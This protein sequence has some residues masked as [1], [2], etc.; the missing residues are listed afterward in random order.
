MGTTMKTTIRARYDGKVLHPIEPLDLPADSE[1]VITVEE[2]SESDESAYRFFRLA[3]SL[4]LEGPP[5]WSRRFEEYL[6]PEPESDPAS[7]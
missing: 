2:K 1:V 7:E 6:Y 4:N 5:D 3:R